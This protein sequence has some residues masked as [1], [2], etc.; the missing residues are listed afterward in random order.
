MGKWQKIRLQKSLG[1]IFE[2]I[3][4]GDSKEIEGEFGYG[5]F[6]IYEI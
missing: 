1:Y 2:G 6:V 5:S 3:I 4:R